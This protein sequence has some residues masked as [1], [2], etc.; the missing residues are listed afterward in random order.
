MDDYEKVAD[1]KHK[2]HISSG[3]LYTWEEVI[4]EVM[5]AASHYNDRSSLWNKIRHGLRG[6]GE[7]HSAFDAWLGLLPTQSNYCFMLCGGLKFI[8]KV[9]QTT[10]ASIC[11][12]TCTL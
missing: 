4:E 2:T 5:Q 10:T 8:L 11:L 6:F 3:D 7:S 9:I 12:L 1:A